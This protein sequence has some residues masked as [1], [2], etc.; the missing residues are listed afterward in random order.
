MYR[1]SASASRHSAAKRPKAQLSTIHREDE[2]VRAALTPTGPADVRHAAASFPH[3]FR[4]R[5]SLYVSITH[6]QLGAKDFDQKNASS[7]T[8]PPYGVGDLLPVQT[9]RA[10]GRGAAARVSRHRRS[11]GARAPR[12][13]TTALERGLARHGRQLA[14]RTAQERWHTGRAQANRHHPRHTGRRTTALPHAPALI[15]PPRPGTRVPPH[16]TAAHLV[17]R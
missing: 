1:P 10:F 15:I 2:N 17:S 9:R 6:T 3:P 7:R 11:C 5:T 8:G 14:S 4:G 16:A 12:W 13:C